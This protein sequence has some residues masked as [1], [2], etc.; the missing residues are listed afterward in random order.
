MYAQID[1]KLVIES[2]DRK[3]A[4]VEARLAE[5]AANGAATSPRD[6]APTSPQGHSGTT[7]PLAPSPT[8]GARW[9]DLAPHLAPEADQEADSWEPVD[10]VAVRSRPPELPAILG[11]FYLGLFH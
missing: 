3:M 4:M 8:G 2:L 6:L 11:L 9:G 5:L 7:S 1:P 10:L